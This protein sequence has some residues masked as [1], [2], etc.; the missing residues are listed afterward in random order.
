MQ[1][2]LHLNCSPYSD[3]SFS[4]QLIH[5]ALNDPLHAESD[6]SVNMRCLSTDPL[7]A[8]SLDYAAAITARDE[9]ETAAFTLSEQLIVELER[10]SAIL[11]STPMHNFNIPAALKLWID[12]VLRN[13]R[14]FKSTTHGKIG[15]LQ[16]RPV[17]VLV[18]SG[19]VCQGATAYQQDFLSPYLSYALNSIGIQQLQFAYLSGQ[20]ITADIT[21]DLYE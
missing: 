20:S 2:I 13:N 7:P 14:S 18:H 12:Y 3:A 19:S 1:H 11:I 21:Q 10:S 9:T 8:I 6:F 15:L 5:N 16:D 17:F 4:S